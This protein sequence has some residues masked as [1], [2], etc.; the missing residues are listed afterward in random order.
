MLESKAHKTDEHL[1]SLK[2]LDWKP[3]ALQMPTNK[4]DQVSN[5]NQLYYMY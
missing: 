1:G 4:Y 3:L 2:T 5:V